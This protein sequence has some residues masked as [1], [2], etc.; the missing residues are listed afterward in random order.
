MKEGFGKGK[1]VDPTGHRRA[2]DGVD[3]M[4]FWGKRVLED[5]GGDVLVLGPG[6]IDVKDLAGTTS[7][8][9]GS[10]NHPRGCVSKALDDNGSALK[11]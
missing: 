1:D 11:V 6:S 3:V 10:L 7:L 2:K 5:L 9:N 4:L 8:K